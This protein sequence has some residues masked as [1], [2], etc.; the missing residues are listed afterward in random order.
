MPSLPLV[1]AGPSAA[2]DPYADYLVYDTFTDDDDTTLPNHT[3]DKDSIGDGWTDVVAGITIESNKASDN[4]GSY[5]SVIDAGDADVTVEATM[6]IQGGGNG[7]NGVLIRYK[8]S[9]NFLIAGCDVVNDKVT[10]WRCLA[11]VWAEQ[12]GNAYESFDFTAGETRTVRAVLSGTS[13]EVFIDG[14]SEATAT[15][16]D[17]QTETV[18]GLYNDAAGGGV[19]A[20]WDNFS[21]S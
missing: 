11:S 4:D 9:T 1:G 15:V 6:V 8:N 12:A 13:I 21:I 16:S 2:Y 5:R 14:N 20:T 10:V 19:D 3:P 7:F 17:F 18:H